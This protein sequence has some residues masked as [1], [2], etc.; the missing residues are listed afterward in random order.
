MKIKKLYKSG[1]NKNNRRVWIE[2][3][4]LLDIG[5]TKGTKLHKRIVTQ[6]GTD[7]ESL[8]LEPDPDGRHRVAGADTRPIIDLNG[9]YLNDLFGSNTHFLA[10]FNENGKHIVILPTTEAGE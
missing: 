5:W 4:V 7:R 3:K 9:R 6:F 8:V 10:F 1:T 2:G